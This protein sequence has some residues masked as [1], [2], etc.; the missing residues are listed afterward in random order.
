MSASKTP[1]DPGKANKPKEKRAPKHR[2]SMYH[3]NCQ[4]S[5]HIYV[6]YLQKDFPSDPLQQHALLM[7]HHQRTPHDHMRYRIKKRE[8][9]KMR[10][11]KERGPERIATAN[12]R[13][14]LRYNP[15]IRKVALPKKKK[16]KNYS[17]SSS[18]RMLPNGPTII[19]CATNATK[20]PRAFFHGE[21]TNRKKKTRYPE[22]EIRRGERGMRVVSRERKK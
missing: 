10:D 21:E 22:K 14:R 8:I 1:I 18:R 15:D 12:T 6:M 19:C 2:V 20:Q 17:N 7:Q 9:R 3:K 16:R 11:E 5:L 4:I 13:Q